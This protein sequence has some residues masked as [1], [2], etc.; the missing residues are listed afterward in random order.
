M[1][2]KNRLYA[3]GRIGSDH[4]FDAAYNCGASGDVLRTIWRMEDFFTLQSPAE[5]TTQSRVRPS[6]YKVAS[7]MANLSNLVYFLME[8]RVLARQNKLSKP[9]HGTIIN[10]LP[11]SLGVAYHVITEEEPQLRGNHAEEL[12]ALKSF[13]A[14]RVGDTQGAESKLCY[15]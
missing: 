3:M 2:I 11:L 8:L 6:L 9:E 5:S 14:N 12:K 4:L 1:K 10:R 13:M 7:D 15:V